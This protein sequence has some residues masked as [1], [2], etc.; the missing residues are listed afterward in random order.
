MSK[1]Y[2]D[3]DA[4]TARLIGRENVSR[5]EGAV[6]ELVKNTY[7]ADASCC[8]LYYENSTQ[9]LYLADNGCGMTSDII[10]KHWMTIGNSSKKKTY[11]SKKGRIQTGAKGIGRFALDRIG[12]RCT[13]YTKSATETLEWSVDWSNFRDGTPLT[14]VEANLETVSYTAAEFVVDAVNL[15]FQRFIQEKFQENCTIFRICP[16]RDQWNEKQIKKMRGNLSTLIPQEISEIFNIYFFEEFTKTED[17]RLIPEVSDSSCDY[18]LSFEVVG[19]KVHVAISRNEFDFKSKREIVI[20]EA[21]FTAADKE[22]FCGRDII[23]ELSFRDF[24]SSR[25]VVIEN[26]IG[27]FSGVFLFSKRLQQGA[28]K[29]KYF[30]KSGNQADLPWKGVR[31]YR[32]NF[33]V[34]PYGD[35]DSSAYDWLLL[36]NRKAKSPAAPSHTAGKWRVAADQICGTVLIS[37]TNIT[38][39]DQANREGF[40]ETPEFSVLKNFLLAVIQLFESDRQ[41]VFKKL[42]AYYEKTH[43]TQQFETEITQKAAFVEAQK[44]QDGNT[45][46]QNAALGVQTTVEASKAQAVIDQR[47]AQIR[48]L[49]NENQLLRALATIGIITNTYVHEIRGSTNTLGLKI[50]M[51]KE[52]REYDKNI[53]GAL[54]YIDEAITCQQSFGSWFK[55]TI[56]SVKKDRRTMK[57]VNL[58]QLLENL[59]ASWEDTCPD[60]EI[61]VECDPITFRC[62]PYEIESM[63][64]NLVANS[65]SAFKSVNQVER[66]IHI[67]VCQRD[68]F[69]D[70]FYQDNGPGLST[71]YKKNPDLIMDAM[72]TDK[73]DADGEI[74]G[75][76]MG[77]W[78][79]GKT[80]RDYK[81]TIDLSENIDA[82]VGFHVTMSLKGRR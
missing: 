78:I 74:I 38:L 41:Y 52:E 23:Y 71:K 56:E 10:K 21:G 55:V 76:G 24:M 22:Y 42:N 17:A 6:S 20:E 19:D 18:K 43:P 63:V 73:M 16:V 40:V 7:D 9:T 59:K 28:E 53:E 72:E 66:K 44:K 60:T 70:I 14:S 27:D 61:S 29:E 25:K 68:N 45:L 8:I 36:S 75:T 37:R 81:G 64:N 46:S 67:K 39:P 34:R 82:E 3:V 33:R 48:S 2:F 1:V 15:D 58:P 62:F 11:L 77:M 49:E 69:I 12:D 47:D 51:A 5:L 54:K 35:P 4:Y 50:V 13:M 30:Y 31:I 79:I 26:T 65:T 32:D 57:D 80:V